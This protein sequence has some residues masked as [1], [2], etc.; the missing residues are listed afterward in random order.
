MNGLLQ[1]YGHLPKNERLRA[2]F[3]DIE[4]GIELGTFL[5]YRN[6]SGEMIYISEG[7][8]RPSREYMSLDE[9][10]EEHNRL[11]TECNSDWN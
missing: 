3:D 11:I 6:G 1:L 9:I 2:C 5:A 7:Y 8:S 4:A 10:R